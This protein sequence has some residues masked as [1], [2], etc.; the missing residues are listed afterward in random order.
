MK[1]IV[2]FTVEIDF[3][4]GADIKDWFDV[5]RQHM[6]SLHQGELVVTELVEIKEIDNGNS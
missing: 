3:P 2:E 1:K 6:L 5:L 4:E